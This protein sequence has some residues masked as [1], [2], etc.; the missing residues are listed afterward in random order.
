MSV[1]I[2]REILS[3]IS[4]FNDHVCGEVQYKA[5]FVT[6]VFCKIQ[7]FPRRLPKF[8]RSST[9]C[10]P[11]WH[12]FPEFVAQPVRYRLF[13]PREPQENDGAGGLSSLPRQRRLREALPSGQDLLRLISATNP[14]QRGTSRQN[15]CRI[16]CTYHP[17]PIL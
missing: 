11:K 14:F 16:H 13:L 9:H 7:P 10:P 3:L 17:Q 5:C 15:L 4:F 12:Q 8:S 6:E 2:V 1:G